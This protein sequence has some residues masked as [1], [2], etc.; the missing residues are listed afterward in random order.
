MMTRSV[1]G[2]PSISGVCGAERR[3]EWREER[4]RA[5]Q[6]ISHSQWDAAQRDQHNKCAHYQSEEIY[7]SKNYISLAIS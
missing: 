7:L 4:D 6:E 2:S 3:P 5:G 1:S